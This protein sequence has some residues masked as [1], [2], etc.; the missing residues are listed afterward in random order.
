MKTKFTNVAVLD[1]YVYGLS[2]G[3]LECIEAAS[4]TSKWKQGRYGHGQMLRV[5]DLLLV[6]TEEGEIVLVEATPDRPNNALGPLPG[7]RGAD[8]EQ[9]GALR[10]VSAGA[11]RRRGGLLQ[12][13]AGRGASPYRSASS[14]FSRMALS[15]GSRPPSRPISSVSRMPTAMMSG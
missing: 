12:A 4:G 7:D 6:L 9:P 2:D 15:A 14:G 3:I 13:A 10:P 1:G 5:G 11:K 8:V